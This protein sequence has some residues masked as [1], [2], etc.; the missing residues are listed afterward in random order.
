MK[1]DELSEL[2]WDVRCARTHAERS[3]AYA[4]IS[5]FHAREAV[6]YSRSAAGWSLASFT[7][8]VLSLGLVLLR[9]VTS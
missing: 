3:E 6:R 5:Q 1:N 2:E 7:F 9:A 4:R 8:A